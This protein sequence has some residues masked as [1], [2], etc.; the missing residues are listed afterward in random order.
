MVISL[1]KMLPAS[2]IGYKN[3]AVYANIGIRMAEDN[4]RSS[5]IAMSNR[6]DR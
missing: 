1:V 5:T 4:M 6:E 2:F 3:K